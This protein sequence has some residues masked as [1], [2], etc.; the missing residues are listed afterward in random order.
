MSSWQH[1]SNRIHFPFSSSCLHT[2]TTD[3]HLV[4]ASP[5]TTKIKTNQDKSANQERVHKKVYKA[6][7][8]KNAPHP[9]YNYF[10]T[11]DQSHKN[12]E[13]AFFL[14]TFF[15]RKRTE[16]E[17]KRN[18]S[19]DPLLSPPPFLR[20]E[21]RR[22]RILFWKLPPFA[23][24]LLAS[25]RLQNHRPIPPPPPLL[26]LRG[27]RRLWGHTWANSGGY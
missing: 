19:R 11:S 22:R 27:R 18:R 8:L 24:L 10:A 17:R 5:S 6:S 21:E 15:C 2:L 23:R 26:G 16:L 20:L 1:C 4:I 9:I 14:H 25:K 13:L 12:R 3:S 7:R